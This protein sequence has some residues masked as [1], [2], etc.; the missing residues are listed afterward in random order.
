MKLALAQLQLVNYDFENN[1]NRII[2]YSKRAKKMGADLL[3]LS[4]DMY[5]ND[6]S[7]LYLAPEEF[8]QKYLP[9]FEHMQ[10]ELALPTLMPFIDTDEQSIR[11]ALLDQTRLQTLSADSQTVSFMGKDILYTDVFPDYLSADFQSDEIEAFD[12]SCEGSGSSQEYPDIAIYSSGSY[13]QYDEEEE[14]AKNLNTVDIEINLKNIGYEDLYI[15]P[16]FSCVYKKDLGL[17]AQARGF[18]EELLL[19]DTEKSYTAIAPKEQRGYKSLFSAFSFSLKSFVRNQGFSKVLLGLSG[20]MDSSLVASIAVHALGKENVVGILMPGAYTSE[21]SID[22]ALELASNLGIATKTYTITEA[23][24]LISKS[25]QLETGSIADQNVQARIRG[26]YLMLESNKTGALVLNTSNKS[27]AAMGYSTLYGDTVGSISLLSDVYKSDVYKL[28]QAA[29]EFFG[30]NPIPL[31]VFEKPA[32]AELADNQS[33]EKSLGASYDCIDSVLRAYLEFRESN[34]Q[35]AKRLGLDLELVN[36]IINKLLM[37]KFKR[38]Q[39]PSGPI[40]SESP[41]FVLALP[42]IH[43]FRY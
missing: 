10:K 2:A 13:F 22:D 18:V 36:K 14:A 9:A 25:A 21:E 29:G 4:P 35:I 34:A 31:R 20:G 1:F 26:L 41:L 28:A 32:S 15:Y 39:E 27:E 24:N 42:Q 6:T 40:V 7:F 3:V 43:S 23:H 16:G 37:M 33:D 17:I 8:L 30:T 5:S 19:I 11:H 38:E 12:E